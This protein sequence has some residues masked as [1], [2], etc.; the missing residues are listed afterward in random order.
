MKLF[1][2]PRAFSWFEN[3]KI[4][5]EDGNPV[6]TIK[7]ELSWGHCLRMYDS[8]DN[9]ACMIKEKRDTL[10]PKFEMYVGGHY[11]GCISKEM[12]VAKNVYSIDFNGWRI[13]GDLL[14]TEY[15]I[16]NGMGYMIA[17]MSKEVL[18]QKDTYRVKITNPKDELY[19]L[20]MMVAI[21]IEQ[22][23]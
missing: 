20:M 23:P 9:E 15:Q 18:N 2:K 3:Y 8:E 14:E 5:D 11:V 10:L 1:I 21:D 17:V 6:Y 12:D 19:V 16:Y 4:F 22:C 7:G 13:E